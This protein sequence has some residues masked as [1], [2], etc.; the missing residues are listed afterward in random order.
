MPESASVAMGFCPTCG[1]E[2]DWEY[3]I[4]EI[5]E[6]G[7]WQWIWGNAPREVSYWRCCAHDDP[8]E[9]IETVQDIWFSM[10][11]PL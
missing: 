1:V 8:D 6:A 4:V 2:T 10:W 7:F 5:P 9:F 11:S 3:V